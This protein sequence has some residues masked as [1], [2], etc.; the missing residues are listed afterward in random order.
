MRI[1]IITLPLH[2]NFGGF[3][4]NYALQQVLKEMGYEPITLNQRIMPKPIILQIKEI[5]QA[6]LLQKSEMRKDIVIELSYKGF[7]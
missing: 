5:M 4:Q 3:L 2:V 6:K 7:S 1:G